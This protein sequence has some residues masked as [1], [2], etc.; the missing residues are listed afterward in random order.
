MRSGWK[1]FG[2]I[3]FLIVFIIT[4]CAVFVFIDINNNDV[5]KIQKGIANFGS[6]ITGKL[7]DLLDSATDSLKSRSNEIVIGEDTSKDKEDSVQEQT[8]TSSGTSSISRPTE[9]PTLKP[10][11]ASNTTAATTAKATPTPKPTATPTEKAT[12]T[13][14]PTATSTAKATPTPKPTATPTQEPT[15]TPDPTTI[16]ANSSLSSNDA[17]SDEAENLPIENNIEAVDVKL[18][19]QAESEFY[20]F[21][22]TY[23]VELY[24]DDNKIGEIP[25]GE[26]LETL[27]QTKSGVHSITVYKKSNHKIF[28]SKE[29]D[30]TKDLSISFEIEHEDAIKLLKY[31][32]S[33]LPGIEMPDIYGLTITEA[34]K[35]LK[36]LGF[37]N[38]KAKYTKEAKLKNDD[39]WIVTG[40]NCEP[41]HMYK[42]M[43]LVEVSYSI[44]EIPMIDTVGMTYE[45][46]ADKLH[47]LGFEN[48]D[49]KADIEIDGVKNNEWKV[50]NQNFKADKVLSVNEKIILDCSAITI[51]TATSTEFYDLLYSSSGDLHAK[52]RLFAQNNEGRILDFYG[53][54]LSIVPYKNYDTRYNIML[55]NYDSILN[56]AFL[57]KNV[58]LNV[59]LGGKYHIYARIDGYDKSEIAILLKPLKLEYTTD[60]N[61]TNKPIGSEKTVSITVGCNIREQPTYEAKSIRWAEIGETYTLIE[62]TNGWYKI[63]MDSNKTGFVPADRASVD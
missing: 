17:D 53:V 63:E 21:S 54:V 19:F 20:F 31:T 48:V 10:P 47:S 28:R 44:K 38:V 7:S 49:K 61:I 13:P 27:V 50:T 26:K 36:N 62:E 58:N 4:A 34:K 56:N 59:K 46:A 23:T 9:M 55:L 43:E 16:P 30:I 51:T 52:A 2:I 32:E 6:K 11:V 42:S 5:K 22:D 18:Y 29:I 35:T 3:V 8:K 25:N 41:G 37:T 40:L 60:M 33:D 15:S 39:N 24:L 14:K 12:P 57:F 1:T 45:E